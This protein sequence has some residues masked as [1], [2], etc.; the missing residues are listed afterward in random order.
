MDRH[1]QLGL[2]VSI[3]SVYRVFLTAKSVQGHSEVLQ[4]IFRIFRFSTTLYL[5][6]D[7]S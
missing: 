4:C 5:E 2:G 7:R 1:L 3:G 6:N